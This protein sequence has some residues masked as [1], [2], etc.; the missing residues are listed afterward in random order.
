MSADKPHPL[1]LRLFGV[2]AVVGIVGWL[3]LLSLWGWWTLQPANLPSVTEPMPVLNED[4]EVAIGEPLLLQL[5]VVKTAE[6]T[7]VSTGRWLACESSN[8]VTLTSLDPVNLPVGEYTVVADS[9][10]LPAKITPGDT[11]TAVI[12]VTYR[13]N[14]MR[15]ESVEFDSEPFTVLPPVEVR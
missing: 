11:C 6:L 5:Q 4:R 3:L 2:A 8:L 13:I 9:I 14:P 7:A 15:V 12:R 10:I 1:A